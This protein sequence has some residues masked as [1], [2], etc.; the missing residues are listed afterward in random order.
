MTRG[1]GGPLVVVGDCLLDRDLLGRASRLSPDAPVPVLEDITEQVRPGGAGLAAL[2]AARAGHEVVLL[3]ALGADAAGSL[4]RAQLTGR[5]TV[6]DLGL[7]GPTPEKVRIRSAGQSLLRLDYG[8]TGARAG[9]AGPDVERLLARAGTVLV[10]DYGRGLAT[11]HLRDLLAAVAGR[12]PVVWDPHPRGATPP[13]GVCLVTPNVA[14]VEHFAGR[15]EPRAVP[16]GAEVAAEAPLGRTGRAAALLVRAWRVQAVAATMGPSGALL[17]YGEGA[18]LVVPAP[19]VVSQDSCG[20]GDCFAS[21]AAGLLRDG[22]T[23]T[24]AVAGAVARAAAF[25][26]AGAAG[27]VHPDDQPDHLGTAGPAHGDDLRG[28]VQLAL[29]VRAG[30]GTVVAT[31]GCFDLLHAGHVGM[32]RAARGLGDALIVCLNSDASVRRLKG[33]DRPLV[34]REDRVR[35]LSELECVDAVVVFDEDTPEAVLAEL[36]PHVWAKGGDYA[37]T[38]LPE[39]RVL[40]DWNGQ[41]V[42]LPYLD[43]RST[44]DLLTRL[45]GTTRAD[46]TEASTIGTP[47]TQQEMA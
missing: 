8:S 10:A 9:P 13:P 7:D 24:E 31:G 25:V 22:A 6:I 30:G 42:L 36:R 29:A 4:L 46:T 20:A 32:L 21:S 37:G 12:V 16:E 40:A 23:T 1:T 41:A 44:T 39:A 14:E 43:G 28:A 34:P 47:T 35:V 3:T 11:G 27:A 33:G 15:L 2:L 19:A 26:A 18:P 5:V 17:S 45:T 38:D